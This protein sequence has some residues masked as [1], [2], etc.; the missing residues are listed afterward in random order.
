LP[1]SQRDPN[2]PR[3]K[4]PEAFSPRAMAAAVAGDK[5]TRLI[6]TPARV[7]NYY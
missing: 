3:P 1:T 6:A 2:S 5:P 4:S 7:H